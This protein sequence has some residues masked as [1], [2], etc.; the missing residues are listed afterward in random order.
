MI[1]RMLDTTLGSEDGRALRRY[2]KGLIYRVSD[3]L[4][5]RFALCGACLLLAE[6]DELPDWHTFGTP[7]RKD[8]P[9]DAIPA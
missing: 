1:I 9:Y 4:A 6:D 2:Y 3:R 8:K 5:A 7:I